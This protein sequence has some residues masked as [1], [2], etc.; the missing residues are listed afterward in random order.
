M[1][2]ELKQFYDGDLVWNADPPRIVYNKD[3]PKSELI[4]RSPWLDP[5]KTGR[6][7]IV[8]GKTTISGA[9]HLGDIL[10]VH[11]FNIR[12]TEF[13]SLMLFG[14]PPC[15]IKIGAGAL[16]LISRGEM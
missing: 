10:T 13:D 3:N 4:D 7:G 11:F 14:Y 12:R 8:L 5:E 2:A 6:I 1:A 9:G 15:T 16:T